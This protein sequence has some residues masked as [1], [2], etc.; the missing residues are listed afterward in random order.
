MSECVIEYPNEEL[1]EELTFE[2]SK[3]MKVTTRVRY[4]K[5][6][7]I[8]SLVNQIEGLKKEIDSIKGTKHLVTEEVLIKEW[9]N[10]DDSRWDRV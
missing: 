3:Q 10:E 5:G 1:D 4:K 2:V 7:V 9:D 6:D 8:E